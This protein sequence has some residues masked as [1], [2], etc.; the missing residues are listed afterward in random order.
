M[1][2]EIPD[3]KNAPYFYLIGFLEK[4]KG[5]YK[6][7]LSFYEKSLKIDSLD[8]RK[9][10]EAGALYEE[11]N[12][13]RNAERAFRKSVILDST[14]SESYNYWGYM[15]AERGLKLDTAKILIEK[16]LK[17]EPDNGYYLDSM[18]WVYYMMGKYD[19]A[20]IYLKRAVDAVPDDPVIVEHLGDVY[21]KLNQ[22]DRAINYWEEALKLESDNKNLKKKIEKYKNKGI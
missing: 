16:A 22:V 21:L 1:L 18:G 7:A 9:W 6:R 12:D 14:L 5:N 13:I 3:K 15:L 4:Q 11:I 19:S 17:Y 20:F 2:K 8:A 10:F